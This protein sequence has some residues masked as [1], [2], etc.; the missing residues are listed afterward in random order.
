MLAYQESKT[1]RLNLTYNISPR[2]N[3][4]CKGSRF[5]RKESPIKWLLPAC[6][7]YLATFLV[8]M[9]IS[10]WM[11]IAGLLDCWIADWDAIELFVEGGM[12]GKLAICPSI[13]RS[14]SQEQFIKWLFHRPCQIRSF[15]YK[16]TK[17]AF[18]RR[19]AEEMA[20]L[21]ELNTGAFALHHDAPH[22][23]VWMKLMEAA[24][25][26]T[27]VYGIDQLTAAM[28][29]YREGL[30]VEYLPAWCNWLCARALPVID[31]TSGKLLEPFLPHHPVGIM[32]LAG[33][34]P[35]RSDPHLMT[36]LETTDGGRKDRSLRY[37][38]P[39]R[40]GQAETVSAFY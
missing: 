9:F 5:S 23:N 1:T 24:A 11:R 29:I 21:P 22:W 15:L 34:D 17:R 6:R 30:P 28:M 27:R 18:S 38:L 20:L 16:H 37:T 26:R 2:Q 8:T 33:L 39:S 13:D 7:F 19:L 12:R 25:P 31:S 3:G 10:G 40:Y 32:H 14:Y 35:E 36:S 4:I